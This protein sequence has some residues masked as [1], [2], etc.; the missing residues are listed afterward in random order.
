MG[1]YVELYCGG[2]PKREV[3]QL[4]KALRASHWGV[5]DDS[6]VIPLERWNTDKV[7]V[8]RKSGKYPSISYGLVEVTKGTPTQLIERS[9][10]FSEEFLEM[11]RKLATMK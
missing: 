11:E 8:L 5:I 9:E 6:I 4:K 3:E 1:K 7:N 10:V 2:S